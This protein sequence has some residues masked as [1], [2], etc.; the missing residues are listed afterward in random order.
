MPV[1]FQ[2]LEIE[3]QISKLKEKEKLN[4]K[5]INLQNFFNKNDEIQNNNSKN[6]LNGNI[7]KKIKY[8]NNDNT[9]NN[10]I[11]QNNNYINIKNIDNIWY[12]NKNNS[13]G[14][15]N[16]SLQIDNNAN[17]DY[18]TPLKY[19]FSSSLLIK[20]IIY[21]LKLSLKKINIA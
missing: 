11:K 4:E 8:N 12:E 2:R 5:E 18:N 1:K 9:L 15:N 14:I 19:L 20:Y 13:F 7:I 21:I 6:K 10:N 16:N 3:K 17:I